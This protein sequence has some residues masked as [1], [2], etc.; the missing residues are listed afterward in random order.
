M[1]SILLTFTNTML[2]EIHFVPTV[3]LLVN[4]PLGPLFFKWKLSPWTVCDVA[5]GLGYTVFELVKDGALGV[6]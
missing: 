5:H 6:W 2:E 4:T 3:F 1:T